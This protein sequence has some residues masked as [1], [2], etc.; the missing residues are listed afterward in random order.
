MFYN[1]SSSELSKPLA[2]NSNSLPDGLGVFPLDPD[3][4]IRQEPGEGMRAG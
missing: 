1:R 2:W 4:T 3:Q